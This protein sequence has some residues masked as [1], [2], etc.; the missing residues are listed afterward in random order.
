[1]KVS[2][3]LAVLSKVFKSQSN[4]KGIFNKIFWIYTL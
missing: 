4:A 1:M 3:I 2:V